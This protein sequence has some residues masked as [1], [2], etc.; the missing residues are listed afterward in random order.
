MKTKLQ[1]LTFLC[2]TF[3]FGQNVLELNPTNFPVTQPCGFTNFNDKLFY[4]GANATYGRELFATDG[5]LSGNQLVSDIGN[6]YFPITN[7]FQIQTSEAADGKFAEFNG[8]LYFEANNQYAQ[9]NFK[10]WSTD[11]TSTGTQE[12]APSSV[13]GPIRYFKEFNGRLYFTAVGYDTGSEVWSTDG[14]TAGTKMLKDINPTLYNG[15]VNLNNVGFDP[16]FTIFNNRLYFI[17]NDGVHGNEIWSTDGTTEGT[18]MFKDINLGTNAEPTAID[19]FFPNNGTYK[20]QPFVVFNNRMYFNAF[21]YGEYGIATE[22]LYSTDGTEAGTVKFEVPMPPNYIG[23]TTSNYLIKIQGLTVANNKL[24][25]FCKSVLDGVNGHIDRGV[26]QTDGTMANTISLL[27]F[28][29]MAGI[30]GFSEDTPSGSMREL[31]GEYYFL[32]DSSLTGSGSFELWKLN[33]IN[34]LFTKI[35]AQPNPSSSCFIYGKA[36]ISQV[37]D[38]K[39]YFIQN[40][41]NPGIYSTDGTVSGTSIVGKKSIINNNASVVNSTQAITQF[42]DQ[43]K[44]IGNNLYF[45]ASFDSSPSSL[46]RIINPNLGVSEYE[47]LNMS[48]FPNPTSDYLHINSTEKLKSITVFDFLGKNILTKNTFSNEE[49]IDLSKFNSGIYL[50][51]IESENGKIKTQKIIKN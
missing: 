21:S 14:T 36:L 34:N 35:V 13:Y 15:S 26:W 41:S 29:N 32:A 6:Q 43:L 44:T 23:Q 31:N 10:L 20:F 49:K 7:G 50:V 22:S 18:T 8:K 51:K 5:T 2:F 28:Q 46:W 48:V 30:N 16:N 1:I 4:V 9:N 45:A 11:G 47:N 25:V 24:Y 37:F 3:S 27:F 40:E 33:P 42:P 38:N 19:A 12:I 39:L 17:A